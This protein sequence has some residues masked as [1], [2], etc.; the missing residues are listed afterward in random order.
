M[1]TSIDYEYRQELLHI[2]LDAQIDEMNKYKW[3]LGEQ[4]HRDPLELYTLDEIFC[5]WIDQN[6]EVFRENWVQSHGSGYFNGIIN[7]C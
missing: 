2:Y 4:L 5:M 6:A 7:T 3:C 1:D